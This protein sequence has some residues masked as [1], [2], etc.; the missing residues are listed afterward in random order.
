MEILVVPDIHGRDFWVEPCH[1]WQGSIIFLGDYHDPY[2]YQVSKNNSR[3]N[4]EKLVDFYKENKDRCTCLLGNHDISY[5]YPSAPKCRYDTYHAKT[6]KTLLNELNLQL[7][8]LID[9][10][11]FSHAGITIEWCSRTKYTLDNIIRG[12]MGLLDDNL[13]EISAYRGGWDKYG[14]MIWCDVIE[15]NNLTHYKDFY[16]V[17]GHSQQ[18]LNPIIESNYACLDCRQC[19]VINTVTHKISIYK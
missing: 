11:L 9:T 5:I 6:I 3:K 18:E 13:N 16:Q 14:S 1:N 10:T 19:F 15:Y 17:F 7:C 2:P 8:T 12:E 4:L